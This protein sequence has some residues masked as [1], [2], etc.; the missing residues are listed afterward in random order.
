MNQARSKVF[1]ALVV[2]L[3]LLGGLV[4]TA[5]AMGKGVEVPSITKEQLK[6]MLGNSDVIVLDVRESSSWQESKQKI[7]G[8]V[9]ENPEK[10]VK[11]WA[12]K[13]PKDKTLVLYCS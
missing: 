2:G 5:L 12:E 8:A 9:R 4:S 6:D 3:L 7:Q 1:A 10:D 11:P 13:Y